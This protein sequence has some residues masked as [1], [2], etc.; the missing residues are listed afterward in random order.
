METNQSTSESFDENQSLQVIKE[1][2]KEFPAIRANLPSGLKFGVPYDATKYIQDAIQE[3]LTTL[4]E[5]VLIVIVV[6]FFFP[7]V[8]NNL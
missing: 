8:A 1:V 3:V 5:T 7:T 6:I 2:R 4:T